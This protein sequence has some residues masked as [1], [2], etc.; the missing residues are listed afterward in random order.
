MAAGNALRSSAATR[1]PMELRHLRY[2]A[3]VAELRSFT[4]AAES[5]GISQ[6]TLS[7][8]IRQLEQELG[9]ALFARFPRAVEMTEAGRQFLPHCERILKEVEDGLQTISDV[10]GVLRGTLNMAV[11]HSF[12]RS[13]LGPT[14]S[15]FALRHQGVRVVARLLAR[16][17][18]ER[19]LA[20]G[21]L[22]MAVAYV[23]EDREHIVAEKLFREELVLVVGDTH[24]LA[25]TRKIAMRALGELSLVLLTPEFASRQFVDRFCIQSGIAPL[26][27]LE[28]NAI[29][30]ILSII[31]HASLAT[32][33]SAGAV[34]EA[35]G[36]SVIRLTDP[37]PK[38]WAALLWRR[39]G[40]RSPAATRMAE[41]IR[42]AYGVGKK[43]LQK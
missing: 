7:H 25:G 6:P 5:L 16:A 34:G 40:H 32:V 15:K 19:E 37:T 33:L 27:V 17:D 8:Q 41:M 42:G 22:D 20:A 14:M 21:T 1:H 18:M 26:V 35:S 9:T 43:G 12:S 4:L 28:M 29:E 13:L 24:P 30:P 23:S 31:R 3:A 10:K 11:F 39:Q 36:L 38:R 2:F